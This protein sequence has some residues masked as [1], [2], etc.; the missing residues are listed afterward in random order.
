MTHR[1]QTYSIEMIVFIV[2]MTI[3]FLISI[4]AI[5]LLDFKIDV[6]N[7]IADDI[8]YI[9]LSQGYPRDWENNPNSTVTIGLSRRLNIIDD[10][11][12][13]AF[14]LMDDDEIRDY[15]SLHGY[16]FSVKIIQ[17]ESIVFEK[18]LSPVELICF[19]EKHFYKLSQEYFYLN[20]KF[21]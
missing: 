10:E 8:S 4:S 18:S 7:M 1:G 21:Q 13:D 9:L 20:Q 14:S 6:A 15:L 5:S 17:D 11:K 2:S 19:L 16:N 12:I 3:I